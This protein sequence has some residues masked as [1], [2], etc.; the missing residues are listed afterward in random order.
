MTCWNAAV[1]LVAKDVAVQPAARQAVAVLA[2][3]RA[4]V[5]QHQVGRGRAD[6]AHLV[7][8]ALV[9]QVQ[10]RRHMQA[11][12]AGVRADRHLHVHLVGDARDVADIGGQVLDRHRHILD[13]VQR[14]DV[15]ALAL[16][17]ARLGLAHLPDHLLRGLLDKAVGAGGGRVAG[18]DLLE[19]LDLFEHLGRAVAIE[20]GD[21]QRLGVV[22]ADK[23]GDAVVAAGLALHIHDIAVDMLDRR[24]VAVEQVRH[25]L[26]RGVLLVEGQ[27][28][29]RGVARQRHQL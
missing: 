17:Q 10:K 19:P 29:D 4:L 8:I 6:M 9:L 13:K 28:H 12:G 23:V 3:Q 26:Q 7:D 14:L 25:Q 11:A 22:V 5:V 18:Q 21:Q 24:R 16:H 1:D 27:Q 20:L 15:A 2:A